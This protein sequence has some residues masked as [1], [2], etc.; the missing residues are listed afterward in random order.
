[1]LEDGKPRNHKRYFAA[2]QLADQLVAMIVGAIQNRE[3]TPTP[4]S[5]VNSLQF[6]CDPAVQRRLHAAREHFE[7]E[8]Q[9]R[10]QR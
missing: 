5:F 6:A 8:R 9:L 2:G 10:S 1:M 7:T 3:V 4:A